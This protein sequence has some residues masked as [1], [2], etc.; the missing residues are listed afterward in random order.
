LAAVRLNLFGVGTQSESWAITA[1]NRI[2][3]LISPQ[4]EFDRTVFALIGRPGLSAFSAAQGANP[5]RGMWAV[6]TLATPLLFTVHGDSLL[7][8]DNGGAVSTIGTLTTS[9]GQVSMV[10]DG[11]NLLVVDGTNGYY[12]DMVTPGTF[13]TITDP[14]FST[15]PTT[16]TVQ[17][18]Y[19][20]V[21]NGNSR[22]FQLSDGTDV[23]TW[24]AD[25]IGFAG[26]VGVLVAARAA[27][28]ILQL[29]GDYFSEFWR[30]TGGADLPYARIDGSGQQFGLASAWSLDEF[31]N[32]LT[33]VFQN[34]QGSRE[35]ARMNG[36]TRVKLSDSDIDDLLRRYTKVSDA[37]AFSAMADG[38]PLFVVNLPSANKSHVYDGLSNAWSEFQDTNGDLFWGRHFA[39]FQDKLLV[40]DRRNG[41]I[42]VFDSKVFDDNGEVFAME[43]TSKHLWNDDKYI[44]VD[45]IQ[46]D[47]EQGVGTDTGQGSNPVI[48]L[49]VSKNGGTH[50][51]SIGFASVGKV[52]EYTQRVIW[53][54]LGSARDWVFKLRIT[55]PVKR[56]I[57]GASAEVEMAGT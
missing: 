34:R 24:P 22:R 27:N 45:S 21:A 12:Y 28:T 57:T 9:S 54:S 15:D 36:F 50:F 8:I 20:I 51:D 14:N 25:Q 1:Q 31:D 48:E 42:Y 5:S 11:T 4:G 33:G 10:D 29:F 39:L 49:L 37:V 26:G 3:C 47:M 41:N 32:S 56:V 52:G 23:T 13:T 17:D 19:F 18:T 7:S 38:H 2:N 46:V 55:D 44:S 53:R 43:V 35:V 40:S 30:N 16:C 6:N